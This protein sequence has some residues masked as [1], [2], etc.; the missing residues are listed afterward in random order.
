M[1]KRAD[2]QRLAEER[3]VEAQLLLGAQKFCGAFYLAGYAMELGLKAVL[4]KRFKADEIPDR[5]LVQSIYSHNLEDLAVLAGLKPQ[6]DAQN[7]EFAA[8]WEVIRG[9]YEQS[10][11]EIIDAERATLIVRAILDEVNGVFRWLRTIW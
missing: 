1:Y 2:L 5:K 10:R 4:A 3:A 11:Y 8:N 6:I 7:E 9:W